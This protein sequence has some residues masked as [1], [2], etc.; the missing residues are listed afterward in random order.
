M[1]V[2]GGDST[3]YAEA[4]HLDGGVLSLREVLNSLFGKVL[5]YLFICQLQNKKV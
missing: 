3:P 4:T 2:S 1:C 5:V